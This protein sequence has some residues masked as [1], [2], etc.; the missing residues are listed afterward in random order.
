MNH[1]ITLEAAIQMTSRFRNHRE[2]I[3]AES[4]RGKI[5][6]PL[7]ETFE[8]AAFEQLLGQTGCTSL[9]IYYGMDESDKVHAIVVGVDAIGNDMLPSSSSDLQ[10]GDADENVIIELGVRC[11]DICPEDSPLNNP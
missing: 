1:V 11:P 5:L 9:R 2:T 7:S 3:L 4:Q 6:L 10:P 8:R